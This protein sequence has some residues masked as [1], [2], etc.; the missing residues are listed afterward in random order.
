MAA[1]DGTAARGAPALLVVLDGWGQRDDPEHNGILQAP[2]DTFLRLQ[3]EYPSC[4]LSCSG[5]EVGLPLGLMGN[6]EVGHTNMGAGRVV[7][8]DITR[9][10]ESIQ[11][12]EFAANGAFTAL[13]GRLA[14]SG[15]RLHLLGLL[16]DG[17]VHS[18]DR[19]LHALLDMA[20]ALGLG[21]DRT[22][23]HA[24]TDGR[25]TQ[26]N[27]AER[28]VAETEAACAERGTGVIATVCGRYTAMD[29]DQRWDRTQRA[30]D[31]LT[32][33]VGEKTATAAEAVVAATARGETDEFI[34]PTVVGE[35]SAHRIEEGD[36]VICFNFRADR[37]R[38]MVEALTSDEFSGFKRARRPPVEVATMTRYRADFP[39]AVAY[40]PNRIHGTLGETAS[41][42]GLRQARV[43]ETEKYAHVT[44]FFNGGEEEPYPGEERCLIPSPQVATYDLQPE[45]S[46]PQV[47][48]AVLERLAAGETD[49]F[50]INFANADM[51]GHTGKPDAVMAAVRTIDGCLRDISE[52]VLGLGGAM[53]IT[54]DHGNSEQMWDT[55]S[56]GPHTAHTTNPVPFV[57]V[58]EAWQGADLRPMGVLADVAPTMLAVMGLQAPA[59]MDARSLL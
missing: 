5:V 22:V 9:I 32:A 42:A 44:Y 49:L 21:G 6:S 35:R 1:E 57:L 56:D 24:I 2:A 7:Y 29:R 51:V 34:A 16:S 40:P 38:Q 15:A 10:D 50:V 58:G 18:S 33:G 36:G 55:D 26:P 13:M 25:D 43:A 37:M 52:S 20:A 19:H 31:C 48:D 4:L 41:N 54:A 14:E 17:G 30:W 53:A 39:C 11:S 23:I 27:I 47:R 28:F 3:A 12:G 45:M 46:A 59:E 8:Q